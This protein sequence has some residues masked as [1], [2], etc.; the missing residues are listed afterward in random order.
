MKNKRIVRVFDQVMID[1][2]RENLML[3]ELLREEKEI[4]DMSENRKR[5]VPTAALAAAVLVAVVLAGTALAA[6]FDLPDVL[7]NW[8]GQTWEEEM[9]EPIETEH[10]ELLNRL[11]RPVGVSDTQNGVTVTVDSVTVGDSK[12]WALLVV[13]GLEEPLPEPGDDDSWDHMYHTGM[14]DTWIEPLAE[15]TFEVGGMGCSVS[16]ASVTEDGRLC[17]IYFWEPQISGSASLL[18]GCRVPFQMEEI[19]YGNQTLAKGPWELDFALEPAEGTSVLLLHDVQFP[20]E[21]PHDGVTEDVVIDIAEVRVSSTDVTVR[22]DAGESLHMP[23]KLDMTLCFNDGTE[24]NCNELP[25][26]GMHDD[27]NN[28]WVISKNMEMPIDLTKVTSLRVGGVDFPL[29]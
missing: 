23:Y 1:P 26:M 22:L 13:D 28:Q 19:G 8:F 12:L 2:E 7:R 6:A 21:Y 9:D 10:L 11:T 24:I 18:D 4:A 25:E 27:A 15:G 17:L 5:R 29:Q 20:A 14:D 3:A 16:H